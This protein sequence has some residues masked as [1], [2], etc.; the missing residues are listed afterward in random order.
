[1]KTEVSF[2]VVEVV[3]VV[4]VVVD[5]VVVIVFV[6]VPKYILPLFF[7]LVEQYLGG[8]SMS[9]TTTCHHRPQV[10]ATRAD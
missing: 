1:L 3:V 7:K 6:F 5:G 2:S 9:Q 4:L 10:H 8:R